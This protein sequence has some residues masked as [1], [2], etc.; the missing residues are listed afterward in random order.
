MSF[1]V[2]RYCRRGSVLHQEGKDSFVLGEV[3]GLNIFLLQ[4]G[5]VALEEDSRYLPSGSL[6][7]TPMPQ[8]FFPA[9]NCIVTGA[10]LHGDAAQHFALEINRRHI[11]LPGIN[12]KPAEILHR[13]QS[14]HNTQENCALA[15]S[16]LCAMME[17]PRRQQKLPTLVVSA[18][19]E[20]HEHYG[21]WYGIEELADE[22]SV[23]KAHLIR[24]FK[25]TMGMPPG[26]YLSLVRVEAAKRLLL[27]GMSLD[28]VASLCGFSGANYLCR[29][30]KKEVGQSPGAW[31]EENAPF[32]ATGPER[33]NTTP[34]KL[35][36]H[37]YL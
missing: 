1:T 7:A 12:A 19:E 27:E 22:L 24:R 37:M 17:T 8:T 32:V 36:A 30:F 3:D 25:A 23:S 16:L 34:T 28:T 14:E 15:F 5:M 6:V 26:K 9:G 13:M 21:E 29:V 10:V 33:S 4:E 18:L 35:E 2:A 11:I 20:I 31:Q